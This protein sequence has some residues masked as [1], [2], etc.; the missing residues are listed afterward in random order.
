MSR[1]R[2]SLFRRFLARLGRLL[3]PG[4]WALKPDPTSNRPPAPAQD[5]DERSD[6]PTLYK[7]QVEEVDQ[8]EFIQEWGRTVAR[9]SHQQTVTETA[10]P[11]HSERRLP[12]HERRHPHS[13]RRS[14]DR[15][16]PS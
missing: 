3:N 12:H 8:V 15:R 11:P 14:T 2:P 7:I 4:R 9:S 16:E 6:P 10:D 1:S 13:D 5:G